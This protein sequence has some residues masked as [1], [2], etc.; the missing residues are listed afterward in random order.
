MAFPK[1]A[2]RQVRDRLYAKIRADATL[3]ANV[4]TWQLL[5]NKPAD[6][7]PWTGNMLPALRITL[8]GSA[9]GWSTVHSQKVPL[10]LRIDLGIAGHDEGD[11]L[12]YWA[13]VQNAVFAGY[14]TFLGDLKTSG[15][16]VTSISVMAPAYDSQLIEGAKA[17]SATGR[18]KVALEVPTV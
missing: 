18:I 6:L 15:L 9:E 11:I 10:V 2:H 12:D 7:T 17:Q 3:A 5:T 16:L 8:E 13:A 14:A 1:C 4:R